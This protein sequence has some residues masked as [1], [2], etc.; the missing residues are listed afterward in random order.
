VR[1]AMKRGPVEVTAFDQDNRVA[2]STGKLLLIDNI[3]DQATST[4]RLKAM[5]A[6]EDEVLWP[7]AFVNARLLVDTRRNVLSVPA[8]AI[9]RGP[10]GL[11]AWIVGTNNA[12]EPRPIEVGPT[13]GDLTIV[14]QGVSEGDRVVTAGHYKL[15]PKTPVVATVAPPLAARAER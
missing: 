6:N 2:L 8:A 9:Q 11:L 5:F 15:Q 3:I 10:H 1:A 12:A 14:T 7:G 13:T 4:I